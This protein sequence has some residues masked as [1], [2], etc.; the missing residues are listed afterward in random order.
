MIIM[1]TGFADGG[2]EQGSTFPQFPEIDVDFHRMLRC[3]YSSSDV[4]TVFEPVHILRQ[5]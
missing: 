3:V 4:Q 1:G 5:S 2:Q